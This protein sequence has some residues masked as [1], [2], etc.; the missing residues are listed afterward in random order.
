MGRYLRRG[1]TWGRRTGLSAAEYAALVEALLGN[2]LTQ[3]PLAS[4]ATGYQLMAGSLVWRPT[5]A[6]Y[7]Q[8]SGR[9]GRGQ[10]AL[11]V[12]FA[13]ERNAH[14]QYF[15]QRPEA[16]VS[17]EVAPPRIELRNPELLTAHLQAMWL[18]ATGMHLAAQGGRM[19]QVFDLEDP[20]VF[21][22]LPDHA[23]RTHPRRS[24]RSWPSR[25]IGSWTL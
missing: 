1:E 6:N 7:A 16:M 22:L 13:G 24:R 25:R 12:T 4:G 21:P 17:G 2:Y 3:L 15:F 18:A 14:D 10:S 20:P 5:P 11:V 19:T 23:H 9:T 8:R